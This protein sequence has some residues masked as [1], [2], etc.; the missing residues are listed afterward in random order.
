M[1]QINTYNSYQFGSL[2]DIPD[3]QLNQLIRLFNSPKNRVNSTLC[4]RT[5]TTVARLE[6]I[7]SVVIKYYRRGGAIRLLIK[8]RYL[9][10]GK[11]RCQ[12]EFDLL[13]KVR[14]LGINAPEPV[15]FAYRGRLFYQCWLVTRE[16]Q[17]H[18]T[19]AQLSRSNEERARMAMKSVIKQISML[20]K[21]KILHVD[22]HPGNVI[23][24]NQNQ[25]Y[26]LDFDKGGIFPGDKNV[27]TTRYLH[28]WN[29]AIKKHGLPE[30]LS[31]INNFNC[32]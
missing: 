11:T 6:G 13:Q 12:I 3:Q 8:K 18:Q 1:Y 31:E 4:G 20:I 14:S 32:L 10:C 7:G 24:D 16:I 27:L 29:R 19:L 2:S 26:L 9:K 28:R 17:D 5:S 23:V 22:L 15:A 25:I 30:M 21:N